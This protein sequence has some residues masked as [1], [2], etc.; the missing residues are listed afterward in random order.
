MTSHQEP[1]VSVVTPVFN[2]EPY[3]RDCIES[4]VAQSYTHWDYTIVNNCSTDRTLEIAREYAAKDRRI[5]IHNNPT[6]VPVI[7]NDNI[8]FRQISL[9]SKYCKPVAADDMILPDCLAKM[10]RLAEGHPA[11]AIVGAYGLYSRAEMGVYCRGVPYG[12]SVLPGREVCRAYLMKDGLSVFGAATLFLFRSDIV[13]RRHAFYN[14]SNIHADSEAC[15][16]VLETHDFGFVQQVLT[17]MRVQE[18]SLTSISDRLNTR[19]PYSLY[20]LTTYGPRYVASEELK[21]R[22][23]RCLRDYYAYLGWQAT[24]RRG[25]DFWK[26][27]KERLAAL[28]YPL[29][30]TRV[31]A[32]T[33]AYVADLM[34]NPGR[35][36]ARIVQRLREWL[37]KR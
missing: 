8:A 33:I 34:L 22:I 23:H 10:V 32:H 3:L 30:T 13:R 29:N 28:G 15:L 4:V 25:R 16:E 9:A 20:A 18:G 7:E 36:V 37:P 31:A 11:V 17:L 12:R 19:L 24:K 5:R 2:G 26:F 14:E 35:T 6:F 1:L 21:E 27:H